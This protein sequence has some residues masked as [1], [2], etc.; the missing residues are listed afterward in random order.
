MLVLLYPFWGDLWPS[1]RSFIAYKDPR[2]NSRGR[3]IGSIFLETKEFECYLKY[4]C[5]LQICMYIQC[6]LKIRK[7]CLILHSLCI[8]SKFALEHIDSPFWL[9][10]ST[11]INVSIKELNV[12]TKKMF[13][14]KSYF[15][16]I[17]SDFLQFS[18]DVMLCK[19]NYLKIT[20]LQ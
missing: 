5:Y 18:W 16:K 19:Y 13:L 8:L 20:N 4:H 2:L 15:I 17:A 12:S 7:V 1:Y 10:K 3:N 6:I 14:S 11:T 9:H